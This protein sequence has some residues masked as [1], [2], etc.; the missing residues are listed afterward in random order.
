MK[1]LEDAFKVFLKNPSFQEVLELVKMNSEGKI[2]VIGGYVYKNIASA[3]Y[4]TS[5]YE[6]DIDFIVEKRKDELAAVLGWD[7]KI[8]RYGSKNYI[9]K[10]N[11]MSFT[12]LG[13]AVRVSGA[14]NPTIDDFLRE[15]P[16]NIQSIAYDIEQHSLIGEIGI[17]ALQSK[18]V[19][20][21]NLPQAKFYAHRKENTLE[22]I[23]QEKAQEL[24]FEVNL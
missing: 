19:K 11:K 23:L 5:P 3:L 17:E 1:I 2:W 22:Q 13:K 15:T 16:L 10:E 12:E 14:L 9:R 4:S 7:L 6:Y 18:I 21:N 20:V 24:G 8:N